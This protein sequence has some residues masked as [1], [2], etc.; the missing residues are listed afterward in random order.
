MDV[1]ILTYDADP[2]HG[3]FGARV[4][5]LIR[6]FA[7]FAKV[8]VI[9]TDWF[10]GARVPGAVYEERR[11]HDVPATR[12]R[13]LFT[14]YKT[15][16]P[17]DPGVSADL[18]VVETLDLWALAERFH[19]TARI[20]DE[21]NVYWEL[22]RYELVRAPFFSTAIGRYATVRRLLQPYLRG[23]A[24]SFE[25]R[26]IRRADATLVTSEPDRCRIA[27]E[28][29][30]AA[31]RLHVIPNTVDVERFPDFSE[32]E[33]RGEVGFIGNYNYAPNRQA[34][35]FIATQLAPGLPE[36]QFLLLGAHPPKLSVTPANVRAAGYVEDLN[37]SLKHV[38]VCVAPLVLGSG[39][40]LKIL[41]YLALGKAVVATSKA[42]EGLEVR[43]GTDLL[44][45]DDAEGFRRGVE[46]LLRDPQ[47][48]QNLGKNGRRLVREQYDWRAHVKTL[49]ELSER[50]AA[51][52]AR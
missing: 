42:V 28:V 11:V 5:A 21:H 39:T 17:R 48:R 36:A 9:L 22:L 16:F 49:Q 26:A 2:D 13:R 10:G 30:A 23:R 7:Q 8:R 45:R 4:D 25:I 33:T 19:A 52:G 44:I 37:D 27:E 6:M 46:T 24:K 32:A 31:G 41:T 20:L 40:R 50:L 35:E 38:S 47:L 29:P 15:D 51:S 18:V 14:Y 3:G 43:D 1:T 34:A 12:V